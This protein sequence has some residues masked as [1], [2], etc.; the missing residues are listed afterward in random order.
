[1]A[2]STYGE[3]KM[4]IS[5]H[6][7]IPDLE[8]KEDDFIDMA[9]ARHKREIRIREQIQRVDIAIAEDDRYTDLPDD[10]LDLKYLR[11]KS[12]SGYH[13]YLPDVRQVSLHEI[14]DM[15]Y[16]GNQPPRRF[17]VHS[18]IEWQAMADQNYTG[19]MVYYSVLTPLSD[20][21]PTNALLELAPDLY[22][23]SALIAS[24]PYLMHDERLTTW[25]SLYEQAKDGVNDLN[26]KSRAGGPLIARAFGMP[27]H[28]Y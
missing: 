20:A 11:I 4:S 12:V 18:Q 9:E 25:Q 24:A 8:G 7:G 15:S 1:M 26:T 13:S 21:N 14:S 28:Y 23:Y 2:I 3:L 17:T 27:R 5:D 6:L 22:L 19:E 16:S 10:F